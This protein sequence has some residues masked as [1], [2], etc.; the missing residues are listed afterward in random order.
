MMNDLDYLRETSPA[1]D[2]MIGLDVLRLRSFTIDFARRKIILGL[3]NHC[4]PV[5]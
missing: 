5:R 2:G 4:G 1:L 3:H